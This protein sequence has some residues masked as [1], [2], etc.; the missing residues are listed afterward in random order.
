MGARHSLGGV[1]AVVVSQRGE[2]SV[3]VAHLIAVRGYSHKDVCEKAH[4]RARSWLPSFSRPTAYVIHD[5]AFPQLPNGKADRIKLADT[6]LVQWLFPFDVQ[7]APRTKLALSVAELFGSVLGLDPQ[8]VDVDM[9]FYEQGG[10]S[11]MATRLLLQLRQ[12]FAGADFSS[13]MSE[14]TVVHCVWSVQRQ[15]ETLPCAPASSDG[16]VEPLFFAVPPYGFPSSL[17]K[18]LRRTK[19]RRETAPDL[20]RDT[21]NE[22]AKR[23]CDELEEKAT[24]DTPVI[25]LGY[26][27]GGWLVAQMLPI[28]AS[29]GRRVAAVV[30]LDIAYEV[31]ELVS[32]AEF[33]RNL[34]AVGEL[35][36]AER[37]V[38]YE[39]VV[40]TRRLARARAP[41][42]DGPI[43]CPLLLIRAREGFYSSWAEG[44]LGWERVAEDPQVTYVQASHFTMVGDGS[45]QCW[46]EISRFLQR[47]LQLVA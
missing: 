19:L 25:L 2:E 34:P 32:D 18:L 24:S 43:K 31:P 29:R 17:D 10:T 8:A 9:D 46:D 27:A 44:A 20:L 41:V 47:R 42:P 4:K 5:G 14:R 28:L 12:R 30:L 38:L 26:S 7:R 33:R 45:E 40:Q 1:A 3:L 39:Q 37:T 22:T 16:D 35:S 23:V 13:F 21:F 36:D 6:S 11:T 15:G